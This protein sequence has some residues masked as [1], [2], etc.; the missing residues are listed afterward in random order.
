MLRLGV[1]ILQ[2]LFSITAISL[3]LFPLEHHTCQ[4]C[5]LRHMGVRVQEQIPHFTVV[6]SLTSSAEVWLFFTAS[7]TLISHALKRNLLFYYI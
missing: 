5:E 6:C 4:P 3:L 7:D 1:E 2:V